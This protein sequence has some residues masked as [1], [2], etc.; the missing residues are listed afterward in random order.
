M[1]TAAEQQYSHNRSNTAESRLH[2]LQCDAK[3]EQLLHNI[4]QLRPKGSCQEVKGSST[5]LKGTW[6]SS[7]GQ[8]GSLQE[9]SPDGEVLISSR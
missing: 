2:T 1:Y 6:P 5:A 4:V 9:K 8:Q 7:K 3:Q